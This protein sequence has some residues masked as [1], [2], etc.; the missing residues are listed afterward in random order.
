MKSEFEKSWGRPGNEASISAIIIK[1]VVV[2]LLSTD[3]L[4]DHKRNR[5]P[6]VLNVHCLLLAWHQTDTS[7]HR[8]PMNCA[9]CKNKTLPLALLHQREMNGGT[10]SCTKDLEEKH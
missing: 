5:K 2:I 3:A 8:T 6:V 1:E 10:I 4:S 7:L 9:A